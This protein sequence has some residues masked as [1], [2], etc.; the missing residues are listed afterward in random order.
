MHLPGLTLPMLAALTPDEFDIRLI[1]ETVEDI[2]Y[3]EHWDLVGLTSMGSGLV[4]AWQIADEFR[5]RGISVVIGGIAASL[6]DPEASLAHADAL[7]IGEAEETWPRL[8]QDLLA[9][10][11]AKVY[12]MERPPSIENLPRPR[13]DLMQRR[14]FGRWRPVQA[15]RGCPHRCTYCSVNAFFHHRYRKRPIDQLVED[16]RAAKRY[17][18]RYIAFMDDNIGV[19]WD[20]CARLWEA[21]IPENIIWMSQCSLKIAEQPELLALAYRSGCRMLSVGIESTSVESLA[22]VDKSWNHPENYLRAINSMR[23]HGIDVSTE[24]MVGLDGDDLSVFERTYAFLMEAAISVPRVHILTP[25]PG[26]PLYR[27]LESQGRLLSRDFSRYSG[28]QVV[29]RPSHIEP[30]TLQ[31]AYWDLYRQLFSWRAIL[32]RTALNRARLNAYMRALV[33]GTNVHYRRQI[34]KKIVPGIV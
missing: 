12:A 5:A 34:G 23:D 4:R 33:I 14:C 26:T 18:T 10:R 15:T 25:V 7:V 16:V 19:D 2:P 29:F 21:L 20:Y 17:S 31:Q 28:G 8:L 32:H 9:G 24:I 1:F 11:L 22:S 6:G 3:D 30:E 27:D 13:Y